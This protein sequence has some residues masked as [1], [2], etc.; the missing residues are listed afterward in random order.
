MGIIDKINR[1]QFNEKRIIKLKE[2]EN[3]NLY[4]VDGSMIDDYNRK[5]IELERNNIK[6]YWNRNITNVINSSQI[7]NELRKIVSKYEKEINR[8][9]EIPNGKVPITGTFCDSFTIV[10]DNKEYQM[11][12]LVTAK[13]KDIFYGKM[14]KEI[15]SFVENIGYNDNYLSIRKMC[16]DKD[17]HEYE[18]ITIRG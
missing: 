16:L 13:V 14:K 3:F 10:I 8:Y 18:E 17:G 9:V 15:Y 5:S 7:A 6:I 11:N 12:T 2:N 4:M 1:K